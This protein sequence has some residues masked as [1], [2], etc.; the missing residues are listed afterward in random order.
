MPA[1]GE[2]EVSATS[3]AA[4]AVW[5]TGMVGGHT[6]PRVRQCNVWSPAAS[7]ADV[8]AEMASIVEDY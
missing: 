5:G 1:G 2:G 3:H 8:N 6:I 4:W 7:Q